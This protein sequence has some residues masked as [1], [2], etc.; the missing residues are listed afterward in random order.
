MLENFYSILGWST[1]DSCI[2]FSIAQCHWIFQIS[3]FWWF[4]LWTVPLATSALIYNTWIRILLYI[5][6]GV[7]FQHSSRTWI[8]IYFEFFVDVKEKGSNFHFRRKN[9]T[10]VDQFKPKIRSHKIWNFFFFP[11]ILWCEH[12]CAQR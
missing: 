1:N 8:C 5:S 6:F 10:F 9:D 12:K 2:Y 4:Y 3:S 7:K 11:F